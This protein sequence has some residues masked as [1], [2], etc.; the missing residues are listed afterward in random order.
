MCAA[1]IE[2]LRGW[3]DVGLG[4][5]T[6]RG[7]GHRIAA[8][9]STWEACLAACEFRDVGGN[10][11]SELAATMD[12]F[13]T[14]ESWVRGIATALDEAPIADGISIRPSGEVAAAIDSGGRAPDTNAVEYDRLEVT[15]LPVTSGLVNDPVNA[16]NGNF[17]HGDRDLVIPGFGAVLDVVRVYNSLNGWRVGLFGVGWASLLDV[18]LDLSDLERDADTGLGYGTVRLTF[19]DGATVTFRRNGSDRGGGADR[20]GW[21]R[22]RR[23]RLRLAETPTGWL[24]TR[25]LDGGSIRRFRFDRRGSLVG[26]DEGAA[27][28][29]VSRSE[30]SIVVTE[31]RSSR[32]VRYELQDGLVARA[33]ASDGRR[34]EYRYD[35]QRRCIGVDRAVGNLAYTYDRGGFLV[36]SVDADGVAEFVNT[37]DAEGRVVAQVAPHGRRTRFEYLDNGGT[38]V[39]DEVDGGP[40][41]LLFHDSGAN[42]TA[43]YGADGTAMRAVYD[44][45]GR[46]QRHV[47][48]TGAVTTYAY[49][50]DDQIARRTDPDGLSEERAHD[51]QGRV[52][53]RR[54]RA[55]A[56][57]RYVYDGENPNPTVITDPAGSEVVTTFDDRFLPVAVTDGDGVTIRYE[58]DDDGQ[59]VGCSNGAGD[60]TTFAYDDAGQ[61]SEVIDPAGR[62][63]GFTLDDAGRVVETT[64]LDGIRRSFDLSPAGR[65]VSMRGGPGSWRADYGRHGDL[66]AFTDAVG[67]TVGFGHDEMGRITSITAPDGSVT[68]QE[69]DGL[70]Q[71]VATTDPAG[72]RTTQTFDKGGRALSMTLPDGSA[73]RREV[74]VLGRTVVMVEPGGATWHR[75]YHPNGQVATETDPAGDTS[76]FEIDGLGRVVA[77]IGPDGGR[78]TFTYSAGSRLMAETTSAGR[79][80]TYGH[81]AAGRPVSVTDPDGATTWITYGPDGQPTSL[82]GGPA[83]GCTTFDFDEAGRVT[84]WRS[85]ETSAHIDWSAGADGTTA[86]ALVAGA[87]APARFELD[88]RE[89]LAS[90]ANPAGVITEFDHDVRGRLTGTVTGPAATSIRYE[91]CGAVST[92][93]D[94]NGLVTTYQTDPLGRVV[95]IIRGA[96]GSAGGSSDDRDPRAAGV[97]AR[98]LGARELGVRFD[99]D[100][101]G[102]V[103]RVAALDGGELARFAY[104]SAGRLVEATNPVSGERPLALER[105]TG[106]RLAS[107]TD[108]TGGVTR[109]ERDAEGLVTAIVDPTGR[110]TEL[111]RSVGGSLVTLVDDDAG[112][113]RLPPRTVDVERR[114]AAGRLL[115]DRH[116]RRFTYDSAGRLEAAR[117]PSGTAWSF[118]FNDLGLLATDTVTTGHSGPQRRRFE[119]NIGGQLTA[120]TSGVGTSRFTY[121]QAGRRT[122]RVDSGG[123]TTTLE[124]DGLDRL[125]SATTTSPDGVSRTRRFTHDALGQVTAIDGIA[126]GWD[127]AIT[128]KP[129]RLGDHRYLRSG[130]HVRPATADGVWFDGTYDDPWG[131][132]AGGGIRLGYR[133]E[134][135]VDGLVFMGDRVYDPDTRCFLTKDPN[136]PV[137]GA[138]G[139]FAS[140]YEYAWSDPVNHLDPSGREPVSIEEFE[141]W[142][143]RQEGNRFERAGQ[144][145]VD[146]PWGSLAMGAM[147]VGGTVLLATPLAPVGAG[148]LIGAASSAAMGLATDNFNPRSVALGAAFGAVPGGHTVRGAFAAGFGESLTSQVIVDGRGITDVSLG[149]AVLGGTFG[150]V[151]PAG[152]AARNRLRPTGP[153]GDVVGIVDGLAPMSTG[154]PGQHPPPIRT[155]HIPDPAFNLPGGQP[156]RYLPTATAIGDDGHTLQNLARSQGTGG[157]HDVIVHGRNDYDA[158]GPV[159]GAGGTDDV[160]MPLHTNQVVQA[161]LDNPHYT[162]GTPIRLATCY[163]GCGLDDQVSAAVGARVEA[164][165]TRVEI[166][167]YSGELIE[168]RDQPP[169]W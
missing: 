73:H 46:L 68:R 109:Y 118:T 123:S 31:K 103:T 157:Y 166:D 99:R 12:Q 65:I 168:S 106:G 163:G 167:K 62:R 147:V 72:N 84:G 6:D 152:L 14:N 148:I 25:H 41:N 67:A 149:E 91:A 35:E 87:D 164:L 142:R 130:Y 13:R 43:L 30:T 28:Y 126:V 18:G 127:Y 58:W 144:A 36:S 55:G 111:A 26:G 4:E 90:A 20:D 139:S 56:E 114:N 105:G 57:Y 110:R 117:S 8:L 10:P 80:Y 19:T 92:M 153:T 15:G 88:P 60:R 77:E 9:D 95:G 78:R 107:V 101:D 161:V 39:T 108:T 93:V 143:A 54:D 23:R 97:A 89:L 135:T 52:V 44:D 94:G 47:D 21:E 158:V 79:T 85:G 125:T 74:D 27:R 34:C 53:W 96:S 146:D 51:D 33:T 155:V 151:I 121:D 7:L 40:S 133:G 124:W 17:V 49:T 112:T 162:T 86:A 132:G 154:R 145:I 104:D 3:A 100:A 159:F 50:D 129:V 75:T 1:R 83:G 102:R 116:G 169:T 138:N 82:G 165:T 70:G 71:L 38:R 24:V 156:V 98:G 5:R 32:S 115:V 160:V 63:V 45:R 120:L 140:P 69:W 61:L 122:S 48:R 29:E 37:Y 16:A 137:P 59:L 128:A 42:L 11:G 150:A 76:R 22:N 64:D 131:T 141:A 66:V 134:L 2:T 136:P 81:D 113:V 119:Y